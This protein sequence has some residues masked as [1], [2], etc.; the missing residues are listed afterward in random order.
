MG[1]ISPRHYRKI[2]PQNPH[3]SCSQGMR[4]QG[5]IEGSIIGAI[6]GDTGS[7]DYGSCMAECCKAVFS[8]Q[9]LLLCLELLGLGVEE[10]GS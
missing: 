7:L 1:L 10:S 9:G 8:S 5:I 2:S 3:M 4:G 6:K